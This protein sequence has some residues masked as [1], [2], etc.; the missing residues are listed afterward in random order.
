MSG[1]TTGT[2]WDGPPGQLLGVV[3]DRELARRLGITRP[4][5][6]QARTRR[7]I[8]APSGRPRHASAPAPD[9]DT[10]MGL[11]GSLTAAMRAWDGTAAGVPDQI[12]LARRLTVALR[13]RLERL[14]R[15]GQQGRAAA[16]GEAAE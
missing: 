11:L 15:A 9:T 3:P 16:L 2:D 14:R 8:P 12:D 13:G 7:G 4:A 1:R 6:V 10:P 5:V